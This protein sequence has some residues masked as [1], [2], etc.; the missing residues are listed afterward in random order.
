MKNAQKPVNESLNNIISRL[1]EGRFVIPDFQRDFEWYPWDI[2]ELMR[3]IF[4]DYYIGNLLLWK[5]KDENFEAL[6]CQSIYGFHGN[7]DRSHIVLDGQQRLTAMY[8]VFMAPDISAP[9]RSNRY[10]YFIKVDL[11][12]EENYDE[13]FVYDWTRRGVNLLDNLDQQFENH[14][15][16]LSV[17]G[18]GPWKM[19][20]W[21]QGYESYWRKSEEAGVLED[22]EQTQCHSKNAVRFRK[23]LEEISHEYK[24]SYL[25]LDQDLELEKVCDIF[26][27]INSRGIRLDVFD[28]IN[29]L[30]RPKGLKLRT[31][32]WEEAAPKLEF[33]ETQKMN[34][35][36]LQVISILLQSY[37]SPKY[38]YYLLPG[39]QKQ[40]RNPDGSLS[41]QVLVADS[42][43]FKQR[44]NEAV[45]ALEKTIIRLRHPQEFGAISSQYLPYA[46]ILPAFAALHVRASQ[47]PDNLRLDAW[48]KLC[49]WYWAC[50]FTNRYS[51]SVDSTAA[52][53]FIDV[54]AWFEDDDS[55]PSMIAEFKRS[56]RELDLGREIRRGTSIYNGIFNLLIRKGARDWITGNAPQREDLD[57]HHIIPKSWSSK[58]ALGN[59][60]D[61]I[62]NRTPLTRETNREIIKDR[63]P[64]TYLPEL[65]KQ[66]G[67][68]EMLNIL[69]SHF[70]SSRAFEILMRN[71]FTID[72]FEEFIGERRR[73]FLNGIEDLLVKERLDPA[74]PIRDLDARIEKVELRL[75][76]IIN[77]HL[78]NDIN[79][80]PPHIL[81][82]IND[83]MRSAA[84][85]NLALDESHYPTMHGKL[86]YADLRDLQDII[87]NKA[88][89][90]LFQGKFGKKELLNTR[91]QQFANL[92]NSIRHSRI[93][94]EITRKEGEAALLWFQRLLDQNKV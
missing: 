23:H 9:K 92:R 94:D 20:E 13:A 79:Q 72:D 40:V 68:L 12:M 15:F 37:C 47:L 81:Q 39:N 1:R 25:E 83:R 36:V 73:T 49:L 74:P 43:A 91:F 34:V 61:T 77:E 56:F 38:L 19:F 31:E 78:E 33:I 29:A 17:V 2:N 4:R 82:K 14:M 52:R 41:K 7:S 55:E 3:S 54:T 27:Q 93:V 75:R 24:I 45:D 76:R 64:N 5:G 87:G 89:W 88:L 59:R 71:P 85:R 21:V 84:N 6:D 86:E 63:L 18:A 67:E 57:D 69:E 60:I 28:L 22:D 62:L 32:L 8:Y 65:I 42:A 11:F 30:L 66:N 51:G 90:A 80:L 10:L 70:I 48:Q 46:S 44:W 26:T 58:N 16:P 50:V 35:Y 53:D